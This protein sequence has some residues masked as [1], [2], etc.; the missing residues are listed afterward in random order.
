MFFKMC[1][2]LT[3]DKDAH[4]PADK[5][6]SPIR[7]N[8]FQ[9]SNGRKKPPKPPEWSTSPKSNED[10]SSPTTSSKV[11]KHAAFHSSR[12]GARKD[13]LK[14]TAAGLVGGQKDEV[15]YSDPESL[16][17]LEVAYQ[18]FQK[19]YS[20][21]LDTVAIDRLREREYGHLG[22]REH[23]CMDYSGFGLFSHWQQVCLLPL[24]H[25]FYF[26]HVISAYLFWSLDFCIVTKTIFINPSTNTHSNAC[27]QLKLMGIWVG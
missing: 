4:R 22:D 23:V 2:S 21:Y 20:K 3:A 8:P 18:N 19:V 26:G 17:S 12:T 27:A 9:I 25:Q 15:Y 13:F 10:S 11:S 5:R 7:K 1:Q 16:P 14:M 24:H 6:P